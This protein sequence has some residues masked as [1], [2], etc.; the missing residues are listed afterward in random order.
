MQ[1]IQAFRTIFPL[2][3][4]AQ[5]TQKAFERAQHPSLSTVL[6]SYLALEALMANPSLRLP[7]YTSVPSL[8]TSTAIALSYLDFQNT[9]SSLTLLYAEN[10]RSPFSTSI[11]QSVAQ[12]LSY[13]CAELLPPRHSNHIVC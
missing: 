11:N 1:S 4:H 3:L 6:A 7:L 9:S 12:R 2:S 8:P 5:L 10:N 13:L